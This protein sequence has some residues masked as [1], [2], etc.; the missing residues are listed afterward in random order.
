MLFFLKY[1]K[2]I[3]EKAMRVQ[4]GHRP[5]EGDWGDSPRGG[6]MS[7]NETEGTARS[8]S[9]PPKQPPTSARHLSEAKHTSHK[10]D[11]VDVED[12]ERAAVEN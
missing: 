8:R 5:A 12:D 10:G 1:A 4:G 3:S 9:S 7:R 6:E 11:E 2:R